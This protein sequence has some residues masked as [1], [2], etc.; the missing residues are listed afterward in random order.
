MSVL[1]VWIS[2]TQ[3]RNKEFH[4]PCS[5]CRQWP[6]RRRRAEGNFY[7]STYRLTLL[8]YTRLLIL[9]SQ[10]RLMKKK[11]PIIPSHP[12]HKYSLLLPYWLNQRLS[13]RGPRTL[14]GL[15]VASKRSASWILSAVLCF[16]CFKLSFITIFAS[17]L[18]EECDEKTVP[19]NYILVRLYSI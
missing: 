19:S 18:D 16:W 2:L 3:S 12:L 1:T 6:R 15:Q 7:L 9:V 5:L 14:S 8:S 10:L 4:L 11:L 17:T 13:T